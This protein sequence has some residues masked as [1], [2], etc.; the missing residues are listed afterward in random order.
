MVGSAV[1]MTK[2]H[3][4]YN[5]FPKELQPNARVDKYKKNTIFQKY[6]A[7][8][9]NIVLDLVDLK[10]K[11]IKVIILFNPPDKRRRDLDN[12]LAACKALLDG[13]SQKI[14]IDDRYFHPITIDWGNGKKGSIEIILEQ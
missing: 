11:Q 4:I 9:S 2:H 5:W 7:Y 12:C 10:E 14:K 3:I 6:K 13:I 1:L 8:G